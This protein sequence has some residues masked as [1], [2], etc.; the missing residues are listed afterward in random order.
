MP[1]VTCPSCKTK[2][3][4][5]RDHL[6]T[7]L[8]CPRCGD[9]FVAGDVE[10]VVFRTVGKSKNATDPGKPGVLAS[11]GGLVI[12]F[13]VCTGLFSYIRTRA[14]NGLEEA[15]KLYA[16]GN[17]AEAMAKYEA[18]YEY[19]EADRKPEILKRVVECKLENGEAGEA[20]RWLESALDTNIRVPPFD[21]PAANDLF[22]RVQKERAV[23]TAKMNADKAAKA[24]ARQDA[25]AQRSRFG[26]SAEATTQAQQVIRSKLN[27]PSEGK[28]NWLPTRESEQLADGSW[29]VWGTV[30]T[31]N[32]FG[33]RQKYQWRVEVLRD[34]NGTW[35]ELV[36]NI[37]V[38]GE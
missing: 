8:K 33:V 26:S 9:R 3:Q 24:K 27:F 7:Q 37:D 35:R 5:S 23:A 11:C 12:I 22:S 1:T 14:V 16:A 10:A 32:G 28:F 17:K 21:S 31:K 6:G 19:A 30:T 2:G 13:V 20:Q 4:V 38:A 36:T 25:E 29:T 15:D 18:G 34:A